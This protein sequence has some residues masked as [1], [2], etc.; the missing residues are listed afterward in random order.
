MLTFLGKT[1]SSVIGPGRSAWDIARDRYNADDTLYVFPD[2]TKRYGN[3]ILDWRSLPNGTRVSMGEHERENAGDGARVVG[4]DG[5]SASDMAGDEWNVASTLYVMPDNRIKAGPELSAAEAA[6]LPVGTRVLVG[7]LKGGTVT[8]NRS[9][10]N[11][12]GARWN[13]PSTLYR[14][15]DGRIVAGSDVSEKSIP[16]GTILLYA[17]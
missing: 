12:C 13:L 14:L 8:A 6:A 7:Y 9:A 11:I 17:D 5:A 1:E 2:G 3:Q 15:P 4:G 16:A 10:F